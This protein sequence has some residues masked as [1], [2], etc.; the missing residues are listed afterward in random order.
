MVFQDA[1]TSLDPVWRIGSQMR[2]VL[3][4]NGRY[5]AR[6]ALDQARHWLSRVGLHDTERV[7]NARPYEL[8]GGMRQR[9][10][11]A[12]A[13]CGDPK[14]IIAD[15][16]TSALDASVSRATMDLLL[17]LVTDFGTSLLIVSHDIHLCME[18]SDRT[19]VMYQGDIVEQGPSSELALS[20]THP[21]AVG[22]LACIPSFESRHLRRLP[23]LR[24]F[25]NPADA[26]ARLEA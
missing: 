17:E 12:L 11:I 25:M 9:V 15:E 20:A 16:P 5:S 19:M 2:A 10:M 13:L 14:L 22:L 8:S 3:H 21:Y 6:Q 1:M 4:G 7:M 24:D 18:Y 26:A 23:T